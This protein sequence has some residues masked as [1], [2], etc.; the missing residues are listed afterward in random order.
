MFPRAVCSGPALE[1]GCLAGTL[2]PQLMEER[3]DRVFR[4]SPPPPPLTQR[5]TA[6]LAAASRGPS[7]GLPHRASGES[8]AGAFLAQP[9]SLLA[10]HLCA[11]LCWL[12]LPVYFCVLLLFLLPLTSSLCTP[13]FP[14][15]R[16]PSSSQELEKPLSGA[17]PLPHPPT[18]GV[19]PAPPS[20]SLCMSRWP[21]RPAGRGVGKGWRRRPFPL[22]S[23]HPSPGAY[24][25]DP[26]LGTLSLLTETLA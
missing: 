18:Q 10:V 26:G 7:R 8:G 6:W 19:C 16:H 11:P 25:A 13:Q 21:G 20:S 23:R 2:V 9:G 3:P 5:L 14:S 4:L 12:C 22:S 1:M 17:R 15:S 24:H